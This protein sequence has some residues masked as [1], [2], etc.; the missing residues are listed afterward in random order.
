[1]FSL[2][3]QEENPIQILRRGYL[4]AVAVELEEPGRWGLWWRYGLAGLLSTFVLSEVLGMRSIVLVV[5]FLIAVAAT[6]RFP[7]SLKEKEVHPIV[8]TVPMAAFGLLL[9]A[10]A[11]SPSRVF[12]SFAIVAILAAGASLV[13]TR[14]L[15]DS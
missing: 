9:G 3:V 10:I 11:V 1:M 4:D 8:K 6:K 2:F 12:V 15:W 5:V 7:R 13:R 14:P